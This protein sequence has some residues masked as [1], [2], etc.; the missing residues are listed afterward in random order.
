MAASR[1]LHL[2]RLAARPLVHQ[3][4]L[5]SQEGMWVLVSPA[6]PRSSTSQ[7]T[8]NRVAFQLSTSLSNTRC[9][10]LQSDG[11]TTGINL[12]AGG[13]SYLLSGNV[14]IGTST[15]ASYRTGASNLVVASGG[16]TGITIRAGTATN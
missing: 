14:G 1:S 11:A 2:P 13:T 9:Q 7:A 8:S 3:L 6:Q 4:S 15:P 10:M 12:D 16:D 5:S